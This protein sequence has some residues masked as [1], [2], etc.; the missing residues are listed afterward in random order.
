ML[1]KNGLSNELKASKEIHKNGTPIL[2][3]HIILREMEAGQIDVA[4]IE[5]IGG[6]DII[7]IYEVKSSWNPGRVQW[8]RLK[9]SSQILSMVLELSSII[10][11]WHQKKEVLPY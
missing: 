1:D 11:V 2:V 8:E 6:E 7:A 9:K 4:K 10:R 5:N 3:S